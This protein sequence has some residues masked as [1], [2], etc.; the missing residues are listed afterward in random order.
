ML[1]TKKNY[2]IFFYSISILFILII[3]IY[4]YLLMTEFNIDNKNLEM[5]Y[6][7]ETVLF[8]MFLAV[9]IDTAIFI[10]I[11][12]RSKRV[13]KEIDKIREMSVYTDFD[14]R[15]GLSKLGDL[16]SKI[17][18]I[19]S[20]LLSVSNQKSMKISSQAHIIN[21]LL[22]RL[23]LNVFVL[24]SKGVITNYSK[25]LLKRFNLDEDSI[26]HTGIGEIVN[27][28]FQLIY[29]EMLK[30]RDEAIREKLLYKFEDKEFFLNITFVPVFNTRNDISNTICVLERWKG[31]V[32]EST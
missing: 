30:S 13:I 16:G 11:E 12:L 2:A 31:S 26:L 9:I 25:K 18:E 21:L 8:L 22:D 7:S 10:T 5:K 19:Y 4:S 27:I 1:L 17:G 32:P 3:G 29:F 20:L 28:N 15:K 23:D 14:I 6:R 24:D